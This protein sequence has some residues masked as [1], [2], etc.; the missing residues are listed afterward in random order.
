MKKEEN[1]EIERE[2]EGDD[3]GGESVRVKDERER[4]SKGTEFDKKVF[5]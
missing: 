2:E 4:D 1:E 3:V 5:D